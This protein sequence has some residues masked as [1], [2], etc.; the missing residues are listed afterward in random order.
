MQAQVTMRPTHGLNF[1]ATWTWSR[2]LGNSGWLN[3]HTLERN[4]TLTGQHRTHALNVF[5]SYD[6]PF[7]PRGYLLRESS[8]VVR[9]IVEGWQLSWVTSLSTGTPM[10]V[11]GSATTLWGGANWPVLVRPDLW[12]DKGG[13]VQERWNDEGVYQEARYWGNKYT[14]VPDTSVCSP[15]LL[16]NDVDLYGRICVNPANNQTRNTANTMAMALSWVNP[17]TGQTELDPVTNAWKA[18]TYTDAAE[19]AKYGAQV[20]DPIIVFRNYNGMADYNYMGHGNY[21]GN[22]LT[23][24]GRFTF[25]MSM[26]KAVEIMEG[27]RLEIRVDAQ[28]IL[29]RA[30]ASGEATGT[31]RYFNGGRGVTQVAPTAPSVG[32][33]DFGRLHTKVGH[34][35]LQARLRLTF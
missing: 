31:V 22:R 10:S 12:D 24:P 21:K 28:N 17:A 34:R 13:R 25:D 2:A 23:G 18:A 4:N 26:S 11:T 3:R 7:G 30:V 9:K 8:G 20:G 1:Q 32:G 15:Q 5:G 27:R 14:R 19:A 16:A 29:N 35:T 33:Y 6:L